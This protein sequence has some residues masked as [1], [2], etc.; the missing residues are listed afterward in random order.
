MKYD[1]HESHKH[2]L[3]K[4]LLFKWLKEIHD[5][6]T[7]DY[8]RD[9]P[10]GIKLPFNWRR[11]YGVFLELPFHQTDDPYYFE[12]SDGIYKCGVDHRLDSADIEECD[13]DRDENNFLVGYNRGPL[14]F[15]PDITIFHKGTATIF[16]EVVHKNGV[17]ISKAN[18]MLSFFEGHHIEV[19]EISADTILNTTNKYRNLVFETIVYDDQL[20]K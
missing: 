1:Y 6:R 13:C 11:N 18:K 7:I 9:H 10:F 19:Y 20:L 2:L 17:S 15:V 5:D 12:C 14:L 3:A 4:E 16:I 8:S